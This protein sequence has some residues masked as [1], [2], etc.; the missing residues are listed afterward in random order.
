MMIDVY[1]FV[2]RP[3]LAIVLFIIAMGAVL[4]C[5]AETNAVMTTEERL[6]K[7]EAAIN[8][9][10]D[11]R[12]V[13]HGGEPEH[14]FETNLTTKIIQRLDKYPDGYIHIEKGKE[15]K[16][17]T[18]ADAA[19]KKTVSGRITQTRIDRLKR[20]IETLSAQTN[21]TAMAQLEQAK[22]LLERIEKT[23]TTNYVDKVFKPEMKGARK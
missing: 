18:A 19:N 9:S 20:R 10:E 7:L 23:S 12:K 14:I 22:R 8:S 15:R 21:A 17:L 1:R 16:L 6:A 4:D 5:F 13:Y 3:V 11:L 2:I